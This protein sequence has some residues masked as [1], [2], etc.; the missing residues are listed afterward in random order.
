MQGLEHVN[1]V[2]IWFIPALFDGL[3]NQFVERRFL[4]LTFLEKVFE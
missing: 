4:Q 2:I 3:D 1:D